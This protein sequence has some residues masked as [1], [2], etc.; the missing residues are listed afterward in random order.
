MT[1]TADVPEVSPGQVWA[2]NDPRCA[3]RTVRVVD[4]DVDT[5]GQ[6]VAKVVTLTNADRDQKMLDRHGPAAAG[7]QVGPDWVPN[8]RRGKT[9]TIRVDRMRPTSTGFRL[10]KGAAS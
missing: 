5:R 9:S 1:N 10:V 6:R 2:D 8:D 7:T 4:L 3:G